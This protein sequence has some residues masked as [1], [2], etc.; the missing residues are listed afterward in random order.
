MLGGKKGNVDIKS[1]YL[2]EEREGIEDGE[3]ERKANQGN[4][5]FNAGLLAPD[6]VCFVPAVCSG[7]E[8]VPL[9]GPSVRASKETVSDS[10]SDDE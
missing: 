2:R 3:I 9:H 5:I 1:S 8:S 4:L 6:R 10:Q 7:F